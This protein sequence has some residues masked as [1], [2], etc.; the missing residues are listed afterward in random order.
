MSEHVFAVV[1]AGGSGTRFWPLSRRLRPKQLLALAEPDRTLIASTVDRV[2]SLIPPERVLVVTGTHLD[3]AT[4][5]ALPAVP[6][7]NILAEPLAK[8]TAPCVAWAAYEALRRDPDAVLAVLAA[9]HFVTDLAGYLRVVTTCIEAAA[10]GALVTVGIRPTRAETGYGYIEVGAAVRADV[11][12]VTRFVE[13]PNRERAE[14]FLASGG[15]LWNSG[16]F[17]FRADAFVAALETHL[18][19]MADAFAPVRGAATPEDATRVAHAAYERSQSI[20]IDNGVMEKASGVQVVPGDFGWSDVGSWMTAWELAPKDT[21]QNAAVGCDAV[22]VDARGCYAHGGDGKV[23]AL[24]G[25]EDLVV[26]DTPDALLVLPRERSQDVR[27]VV[28]ALKQRR[29]QTL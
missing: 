22:F 18:P 21:A 11:H 3:D 1:M 12:A 6:R 16:Q 13:K 26:V 4:A 17:F 25:V 7:A 20:S 8:N 9:D 29:P 27:A 10:S 23:I 24:V 14:A 2:A 5:R 28:D 19:A 15:F